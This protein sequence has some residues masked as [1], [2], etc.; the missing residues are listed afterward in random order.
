MPAGLDPARAVKIFLAP[1]RDD[2][3]HRIDARFDAMMA[4]G[5]LDEVQ[6]ARG[7]PARSDAAGDEGARRAL[8][9]SSPRAAR[10]RSIRPSEEAK[11]DTRQYTKRQATWFRNQLPDFA[12][13]EPDARADGDRGA[14]A[15][16]AELTR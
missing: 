10:S 2:L 9:G 7:A 16:A 3:L 15:R 4:A 14:V 13:V 1:D 6:V 11:R 5:A 12:W 8:A